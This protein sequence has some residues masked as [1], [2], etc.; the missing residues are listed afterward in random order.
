MF[1]VGDLPVPTFGNCVLKTGAIKWPLKLCVRFLRFFLN[2]KKHV[3]Y[4]VLTCCT[5]FYPRDA[6]LARVLAVCLS[7]SV[8]LSQVGVLSKQM[9][10][11]NCFL[12]RELP[13]T[14]P[15]LC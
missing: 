5:R 14:C 10:E 4:V 12:A 15:T 7:V 13:F 8:C 2:P 6:T 11:S 3:F 9:D 1:D